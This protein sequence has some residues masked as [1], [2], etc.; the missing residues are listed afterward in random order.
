MILGIHF[1][2]I[3]YLLSALVLFVFF[4]TYRLWW[5]QPTV[6]R[7]SLTSFIAAKKLQSSLI[8]SQ[9]FFFARTIALALMV[10]LIGQPQLIDRKSKISLN[11]IDIILAMDVS[12]SMG[13]FDDLSDKRSRIEVAKQEAL[14][15]I[16][17]RVNDAIGVVIFGRYALARCPITADKKILHTIISDLALGQPTQDMQEGT[18]LFKG[19]LTAC[20]RLKN[21]KAKSKII[22]L[23]TDGAPTPG[24]SAYQD[25]LKIAKDL[26]VKIYTIGIGSDQGGYV[27][28]PF[29]VQRYAAFMNKE[30]LQ[31]VA[32]Q[33]GGT[34]FEAKNP[35]DL[36]KI[37][38]TIDTLEKRSIENDMYQSYQDWFLPL[39][40]VVISLLLF[41]LMVATW[42]W[43]I[44]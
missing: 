22:V 25:A 42:F 2:H 6:Y 21:S 32:Q 39:L 5:Y 27:N 44:V 30:L 8:S 15:F 34:F 16:D 40:W 3:W 13:L 23:L 4:V 28:T 37:Y 18:V 41:E 43:F 33:T 11:G 35:K 24:D 19:L 17:K 26:G 1:A 9:F 20:S 10:I 36:A 12:G 38:N 29:G 7:Y 31:M 14:T